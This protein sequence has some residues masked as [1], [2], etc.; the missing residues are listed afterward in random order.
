MHIFNCFIYLW[1]FV[2]FC[3]LLKTLNHFVSLWGP[4]LNP[5]LKRCCRLAH[6]LFLNNLFLVNSE[7]KQWQKS[8]KTIN[9][10]KSHLITLLMLKLESQEGKFCI[11]KSS[12]LHLVL[13]REVHLMVCFQFTLTL[14]R[15]WTHYVRHLVRYTE[16]KLMLWCTAQESWGNKVRVSHPC[17]D[18]VDLNLWPL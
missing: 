16:P 17:V 18:S 8:L 3:S 9:Y 10:K 14:C 4:A 1:S 11:C 6:C 12:V 13:L 2:C 15:H 5:S 7:T